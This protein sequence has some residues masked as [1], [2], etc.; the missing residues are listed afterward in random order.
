MVKVQL[1]EFGTRYGFE[2]FKRCCKRVEVKFKR[3]PRLTPTFVLR[4][5]EKLIGGF[6]GPP[7]LNTVN[8]AIMF[9]NENDLFCVIMY[10]NKNFQN[11]MNMRILIATTEFNY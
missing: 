6:F 10:G 9:F 7:I 2:I 1:V 11:N 5:R 3:F 4:T 8:D